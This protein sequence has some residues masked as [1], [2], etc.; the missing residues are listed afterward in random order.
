MIKAF[1]NPVLVLFVVVFSFSSCITNKNLEYINTLNTSLRS[2]SYNYIVQKEDLLSVQISS[3][4]KSDYDFFN[5]QETSNPQLMHQNP[6]LYGY[7][8]K[9]DGIVNLP[10]IGDIKVEGFTISEVEKVIEQIS[11]TY[12]KDP[13]VKVNVLNFKVSILGEVNSPGEYNIVRSNQ[14]LLHLLGKAN[15]LTEFANRKKIKIIRNNGPNSSNIIYLDL[16]D[17]NVL[18][19]KDF[20]LQPQD[21]VYIEPLKKKFY[22][23]RNL[24]SAVSVS[25]SAITLYLLLI[26]N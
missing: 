21:V 26:N 20:Y 5:L 24:S 9:P 22:S 16:T 17:P 10:M 23:V 18:N 14:N 19:N 6:Y 2:T 8:V 13:I 4:T 11:S 7:L 3:T 15:D 1:I 12:F 25:V